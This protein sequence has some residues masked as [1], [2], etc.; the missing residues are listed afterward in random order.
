MAHVYFPPLALV[1]VVFTVDGNVYA[2]WLHHHGAARH[3]ETMGPAPAD[4][5]GW[6]HS[7]PRISNIEPTVFLH[8]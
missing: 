7:Q 5:A 2:L 4:A 1:T 3:D 6:A 8:E